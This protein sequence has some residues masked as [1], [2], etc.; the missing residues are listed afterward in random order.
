MKSGLPPACVFLTITWPG[1][2]NN[3]YIDNNSASTWLV[4]TARNCTYSSYIIVL[5]KFNLY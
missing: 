3:S 2:T 1:L 5:N 4:A